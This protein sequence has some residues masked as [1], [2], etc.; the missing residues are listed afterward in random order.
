[1]QY[2]HEGMG[3]NVEGKL[4]AFLKGLGKVLGVMAAVFCTLA[5]IGMSG[6]QT[7]KISVTFQSVIP[8]DPDVVALVVGIVVA[9]VLALIA[10]APLLRTM[11][12]AAFIISSLVTFTFGGITH[13]HYISL[14]I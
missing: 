9:I 4:G 3:R 10:C 2:L 5:A 12:T 14:V 11:S 7:N 8:A 13:L 6:V 1:M